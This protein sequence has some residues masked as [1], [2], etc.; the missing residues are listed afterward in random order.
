M[1]TWPKSAATCAQ[2]CFLRDLIGKSQS[3]KQTNP[4]HK[5]ASASLDDSTGIVTFKRHMF[6]CF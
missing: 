5:Q 1:Q 2:Q 3:K 6:V 4:K